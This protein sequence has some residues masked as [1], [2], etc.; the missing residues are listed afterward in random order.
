MSSDSSVH[1]FKYNPT[2]SCTHL[3]L[4]VRAGTMA[5]AGADQN[6]IANLHNYVKI[7]PSLAEL[8]DRLQLKRLVPVA[9]DR[10]IVDIIAPVVER[11]CFI[12]CTTTQELILKAWPFLPGYEA[13]EIWSKDPLLKTRLEMD[14]GTWT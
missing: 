8:A 5:A 13:Q 14:T 10:A 1:L 6:L 11:S 4:H 2:T 9:V 7:N 12:A 3:L